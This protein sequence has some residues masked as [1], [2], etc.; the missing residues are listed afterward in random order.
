[1]MRDIISVGLEIKDEQLRAE[2]TQ[3]IASHQEFLVTPAGHPEFP[4]LLI[5]EMDEERHSTFA[6]IQWLQTTAP[7]SEIFLT[8]AHI[9]TSVVL[10]ALRAGVKEVL[11]QPLDKEE[12]EHALQRFRGRY[13]ERSHTRSPEPAQGGKLLSV[14]GSKGGVGTTTI[15]VN[16]AIALRAREKG[17]SVV[18]VDMN[19]QGGD[20]ALFL[21]LQPTHTFTDLAKNL[22]RL[23]AT[24]VRSTLS[25]HASGVS[26]LPSPTV[27]DELD[28][29]TP[30]A[31]QKT[32]L[33]LQAA[34]EYIVIDC[35]HVLDETTL[36]VLN[37]SSAVFL[38]S[39]VTPLI[40]HKTRSILDLFSRL[41]RST[42]HVKIIMNRYIKD[43]YISL[44]EV[45][46][47]LTRRPFWL[48]PNDY[49]T[50]MSAINAG[51][52]LAGIAPR[53]SITKNFSRLVAS[54]T[55]DPHEMT[56]SSLFSRVWKHKHRKV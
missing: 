2:F 31:A 9:D 41:E 55:A 23:D 34:F 10:E 8:S 54:F 42:D 52:P 6:H 26:L 45:E 24:L 49:M 43:S 18:L 21:D 15:A 38:I 51:E 7:A 36:A 50:T 27:I 56:H 4:H 29:V 25:K 12:V 37:M 47:L 35:G 11:P 33:L 20:V 16:L 40:L 5:L 44:K 46:R 19:P 53:A 1:M 14:F 3:L 17:R 30:E 39:I 13:E 22:S 28:S 48:I 32:L